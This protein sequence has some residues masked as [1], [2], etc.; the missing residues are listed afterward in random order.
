MPQTNPAPAEEILLTSHER[1]TE[2]FE[3]LFSGYFDRLVAHCRGVGAR[4][5]AEDVA[6]EALIRAWR[7]IDS[8]DTSRQMWP[9]LKT[10][11][12]N[13][14]RDRARKRLR[15]TPL[16]ASHDQASSDGTESRVEERALLTEAMRGLTRAQRT[17]LRLRY[18]EDWETVDVARFLGLSVPAMKQLAYRARDRLRAEYRRLSEGA[19]GWI[20]APARLLRRMLRTPASKLQ[21]DAGRMTPHLHQVGESGYQI[22]IGILGLALM[23]GGWVPQGPIDRSPKDVTASASNG[24]V[25]RNQSAISSSRDRGALPDKATT[26][27][28]TTNEGLE[29]AKDPPG[30]KRVEERAGDLIAFVIDPNGRTEQPEDARIH[31]VALSPGFLSDGAVFLAGTADCDRQACPSVLFRSED[32]GVNWHR[33]PAAGMVADTLLLPPSYGRGDDRIF[34]MGTQGL[35]VSNDGGRTFRPALLVTGP[36]TAGAAAISPSFNGSDPSILI[37]AEALAR[38]RDDRRTIEPA[39]STAA[40][41]PFQPAYSPGYA[42]DR[43]ILLGGTRLDPLT[44]AWVATIYTCVDALC[45]ST[46]LDDTALIPKVRPAPDFATSGVVYAFLER[47]V[48]ASDDGGETFTPLPLGWSSER[49]WDLAVLEGGALIAATVPEDPDGTAGVYLSFD[50]GR[51]WSQAQDELLRRGAAAIGVSGQRIVVGLW[52]GGI[53]CSADAGRTWAARCPPLP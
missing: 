46:D 31:S 15:E 24:P 45:G 32:G 4:E 41:G 16:E 29:E 28:V 26:I 38:Y 36:Q 34:T 25:L 33:E 10:I 39:P 22:M 47:A 35:L 12:S 20:L 44:G 37:G 9:W 23:F 43:T 49:L 11:A 21:R 18:L 30:E 52:D 17:A 6:Q 42:V 3:M 5:E 27:S 40:Q 50:G 7:N 14:A 19:L 8:F 51:T 2:V 53:A 1:S 48:F 13:L